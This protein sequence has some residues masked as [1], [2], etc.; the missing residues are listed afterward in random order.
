MT[1]ENNIKEKIEYEKGKCTKLEEKIAKVGGR[2]SAP[3]INLDSN[4][5]VIKDLLFKN[6]LITKN[7]FELEFFGVG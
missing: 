4:L 5:K 3:L 1:T 7:E 6:N 2:F